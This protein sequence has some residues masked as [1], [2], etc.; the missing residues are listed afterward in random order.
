MSEEQKISSYAIGLGLR[1][2]YIFCAGFPKNL[3]NI[4]LK[5]RGNKLVCKINP[6]AK[7]LMDKENI[8]R[9]KNFANACNLHH[10]II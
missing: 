10:E 8:R 4:K 5:I 1:F 2:V 7:A 3:E 9:F 6:D